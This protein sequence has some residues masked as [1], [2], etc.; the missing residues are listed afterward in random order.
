MTIARRSLLSA[1]AFGVGLKPEFST[2]KVINI[3]DLQGDID[4][5]IQHGGVV[6]LPAGTI[7]VSGI[8]INQYIA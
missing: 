6:H 3:N 4:K 2:I 1:A 5:A 7:V 8:K